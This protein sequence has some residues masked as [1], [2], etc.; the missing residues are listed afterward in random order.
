MRKDH[1]LKK[2]PKSLALL[3][4]L[5]SLDTTENQNSFSASLEQESKIK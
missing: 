4:E 1:L 2:N 5:D 3:D